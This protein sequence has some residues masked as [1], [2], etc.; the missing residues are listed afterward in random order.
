MAADLGVEHLQ[1]ETVE[2]DQDLLI[3]IQVHQDK[4]TPEA[5]AAEEAKVKDLEAL[6]EQDF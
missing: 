3:H 2:V 6:E 1:A 4:L 5:V